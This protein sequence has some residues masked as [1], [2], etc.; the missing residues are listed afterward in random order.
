MGTNFELWNVS[1][2]Q[3]FGIY[4]SLD[5]LTCIDSNYTIIRDSIFNLDTSEDG[6]IFPVICFEIVDRRLQM[7]LFYEIQENCDLRLVEDG[8]ESDD[9]IIFETVNQM[10]LKENGMNSLIEDDFTLCFVNNF[11]KYRSCGNNRMFQNASWS[12][13]YEW[14][15]I[16][17]CN[18]N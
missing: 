3:H 18:S 15:Y 9:V 2:D 7:R 1:L 12:I 8:C 16:L 5:I 10:E 4:D 14:L 6:L 13:G 17:D 11:D